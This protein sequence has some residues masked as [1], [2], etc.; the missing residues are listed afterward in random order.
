VLASFSSG[1]SFNSQGIF[2][3][4]DAGG[5][6]GEIQSA[7]PLGRTGDLAEEFNLLAVGMHFDANVFQIF[8]AP[9]TLIHATFE[10]DTTRHRTLLQR[11]ATQS[12]GTA[13][14]LLADP[15]QG[16]RILL[17]TTSAEAQ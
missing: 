4:A 15:T 11:A 6:L 8:V 2:D 1:L 14:E 12:L 10:A 3:L 9:Q 16:I 13:P 7:L 17:G 5:G